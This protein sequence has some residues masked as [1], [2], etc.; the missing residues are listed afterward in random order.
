MEEYILVIEDEPLQLSLI[1]DRIA[2]EFPDKQIHPVSSLV[3]AQHLIKKHTYKVIV[4]DLLM[5]EEN[6]ADQLIEIIK[7]RGESYVIVYTVAPDAFP[8]EYIDNDKVYL[9]DKLHEFDTKMVSILYKALTG[10]TD[11]LAAAT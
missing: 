4:S 3:E 8:V 1:C 9:C 6:G 5:G 7:N 10:A 2:L 11:L